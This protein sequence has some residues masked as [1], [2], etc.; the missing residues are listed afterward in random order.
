LGGKRKR[1]REDSTG[2]PP[3]EDWREMKE[4]LP[5]D[6]E[7]KEPTPYRTHVKKCEG[8]ETALKEKNREGVRKRLTTPNRVPQKK[9][10]GTKKRTLGQGQVK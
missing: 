8:N 1:S 10:T 9:G 7:K 2:L 3:Q 5:I 6:R 4:G